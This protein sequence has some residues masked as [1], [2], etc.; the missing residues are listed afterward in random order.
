[1]R[2][3]E[4][5]REE[6]LGAYAHGER[7][8]CCFG[9]KA[10]GAVRI[11]AVC[12]DDANSSLHITSTSVS[13]GGSFESLADKI[14]SMHIYEREIF[15][16]F[17]VI[18]ENHP[19][20][21]PVRYQHDR[22]DRNSIIENYPFFRME[23]D[24]IHEVGV[25]PVHAGVIEPGH[26]R[27]MCDG[28][29]VHHLEIQLG[30]QHRGVEK[31]LLEG[32]I[33]SKSVLVEST[34]GDTTIGHMTAY[35]QAL[36]SLADVYISRRTAA[37]RGIMLELERIGIHLGDLSAIS[38]DIAYLSGN[39]IFGALRTY[40]INTS[41]SICGNRFGKG[42][43]RPGGVLFDI[44]DQ[45]SAQIRATLTDVARRT[46]EMANEMFSDSG[47]LSRLEMTGVVRAETAKA[48]GM[49]GPCARASA[50]RIDSRSDHPYGIYRHFPVF[51][52]AL[53][54][55]DVFARAYIRY[56]EIQ[57]SIDFILEILDSFPEEAAIM[58]E[59]RSLAPDSLVISIAEGW[60]GEIVHS[61]LTDSNG[62][63][64]RYN[65]KDPSLHNWLALALSVRGNGISDFPLC[66]KSFNLS[67]CGSDL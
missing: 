2:D 12:S 41:Q 57:Q 20:L 48:I 37:L 18:P 5:F 19:W 22:A 26:F 64:F 28:E 13:E 39:A 34:C 46:D 8:L 35:A 9:V 62:K 51:P 33:F 44:D 6:I 63:V 30:Y 21:K 4:R 16:Q 43:I 10:D 14:P 11:F 45:L 61:V 42:M 59:V 53:E 66:N 65:I 3:P 36:E 40:I 50:L 52:R 25:G 67:Y 54:T 38:G 1:M 31:L 29:T 56:I 55:G 15:E 23:G 24:Q 58:T 17:A 49:T 47:V 32:N 27:F 60:R 7:I